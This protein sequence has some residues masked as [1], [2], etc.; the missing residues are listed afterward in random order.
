MADKQ[1]TT[2]NT[3]APANDKRERLG[4]IPVDK[5]GGIVGAK[6]LADY[7]KRAE[8]MSTARDALSKL[9]GDMTAAIA[10]KLSLGDR[11]TI[12]VSTQEDKAVLFRRAADKPKKPA[13]SAM[14]DLTA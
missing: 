9:K 14:V 11:A 7:R 6:A 12:D 5:L 10:K 2:T 4:M 8:E 3:A 1:T 13:K